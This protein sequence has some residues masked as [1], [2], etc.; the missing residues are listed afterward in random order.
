[1]TRVGDWARARFEGAAVREVDG[2]VE[3]VVDVDPPPRE[4]GIPW[5]RCLRQTVTMVFDEVELMDGG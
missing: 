2:I 1:M 5:V 4:P 3:V